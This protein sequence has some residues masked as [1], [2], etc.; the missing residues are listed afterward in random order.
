MNSGAFLWMSVAGSPL[1]A[2]QC[3]PTAV[4]AQH[5]NE[6]LHGHVARLGFGP[7]IDADNR[8]CFTFISVLLVVV[9]TSIVVRFPFGEC[10][11]IKFYSRLGADQR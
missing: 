4:R 6:W 1:L 5:V 10:C 2:R 3:R 11:R 9:K 8:L 7:L